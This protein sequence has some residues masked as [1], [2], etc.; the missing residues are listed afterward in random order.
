MQIS[1]NVAGD[2][3]D[4]NNFPH[5][6]FLTNTLVATLSKAF[7]NNFSANIKFQKLNC[8]K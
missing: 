6:L 1:S 3:N 2:S 4:E 7:A 5:K 8:I